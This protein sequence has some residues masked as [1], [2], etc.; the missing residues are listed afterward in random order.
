MHLI[1]MG[2]KLHQ[3]LIIRV[4]YFFK[5]FYFYSK[6]LI[7]LNRKNKLKRLKLDLRLKKN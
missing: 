6:F 5:I 1:Q 3:E 7:E 2:T 4:I